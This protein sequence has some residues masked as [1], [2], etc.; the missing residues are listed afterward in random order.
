[1]PWVATS[2]DPSDD[3]V[4]RFAERNGVKVFRGALDNVALRMLEAAQAANADA[5]V[6]VNGDSPLLDPALV[7]RAAHLFR[8]TLVD[9]VANVSPRSFAKGQSVEVI[10]RGALATA[11]MRMVRDEERE[12]VTLHFYA[13]PDAWRIRSFTAERPRPELQLS[14]DEGADLAR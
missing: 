1:A 5:V 2:I 11:L 8:E 10:S 7:D 12:H 13:H 9:L 3:A 4:E 6:R 14:I